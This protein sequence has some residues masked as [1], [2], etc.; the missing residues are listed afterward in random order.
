MTGVGEEGLFAIIL[1]FSEETAGGCDC[2]QHDE[3]LAQHVCL[4]SVRYLL[5]LR[6]YVHIRPH[7]SAYVSVCI[8]RIR[9]LLHPR[10]ARGATA[11]TVSSSTN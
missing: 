11:Q 1:P 5:H 8:A 10:E 3:R 4:A 9:Y 7:T 6:A 2:A